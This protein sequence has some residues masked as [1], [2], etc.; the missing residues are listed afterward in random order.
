M[1]SVQ[2]GDTRQAQANLNNHHDP[3]NAGVAREQ[4]IETP[5]EGRNCRRDREVAEGCQWVVSIFVG[6]VAARDAL[7]RHDACVCEVVAKS[8]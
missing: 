7:Q 2:L 6:L 3:V 1:I 5:K 4:D 8:E